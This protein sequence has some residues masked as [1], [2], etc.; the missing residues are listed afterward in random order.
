MQKKKKKQIFL[1]HNESP[2]TKR[3]ELLVLQPQK[4]HSKR[5]LSREAESLWVQVSAVH[6]ISRCL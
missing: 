5:Q 1:S 2:T 3:T 6:D 4:K